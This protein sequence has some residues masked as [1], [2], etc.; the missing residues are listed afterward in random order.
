MSFG[1]TLDDREAQAAASPIS[2]RLPI[3]IEN[4]G[5]CRR[6]NPDT[7]VLHLQLK[8]R[9][10]VDDT[11]ADA[12]PARSEADRVS[13]EVDHELV[14]PLRVAEVAEVIPIAL[15]LQVDAGLF[16]LRMKLLDRALHELG[17]VKGLAVKL[18][19]VG[20]KRDISRI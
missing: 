3:G 1:D 19:P 12:P 5:E 20:A 7:G 2:V 18:D 13:A 6:G 4:G 8:L 17:E 11:D 9:P 15:A 14:Q 16:G 10:G